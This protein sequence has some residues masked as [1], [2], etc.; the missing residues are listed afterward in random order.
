[1][2]LIDVIQR[3]IDQRF[4]ELRRVGQVTAIVGTKVTVSL[5]GGGTMTLP[6]MAHYTPTVGDKVHIDCTLSGSWIVVG[7]PA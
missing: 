7:K 2:R 4:A 5:P 1:M 3:I 6:R